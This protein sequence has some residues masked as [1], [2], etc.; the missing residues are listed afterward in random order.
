MEPRKLSFA[1]F[2][3]ALSFILSACEEPPQT[4]V[5]S[6]RPVKTI[7]I[8]DGSTGDTRTF[9]AVVDA[10]QKAD[11]SLFSPETELGIYVEQRRKE[12][13]TRNLNML[14]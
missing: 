3:L 7:V 2:T 9:P 12:Y 1:T 11:P 10:I 6:S 4:Y 14:F 13:R 8:G 5:A